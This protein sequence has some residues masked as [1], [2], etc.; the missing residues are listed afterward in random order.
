[1]LD[2]AG[3]GGIFAPPHNGMGS[4]AEQRIRDA[5]YTGTATTAEAYIR[6]SILDPTI[7]LVPGYEHT[8]YHMPAYT[9]LPQA[10]LDALVQMLLH[11]GKDAAQ[12]GDLR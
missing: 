5:G 7:Y 12:H 8:R 10:D 2:A 11:E 3:A 4:L 6:E 1:M 9:T